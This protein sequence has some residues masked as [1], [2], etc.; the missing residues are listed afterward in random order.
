MEGV[1]LTIER[2]R[3]V[4]RYD[5]ETGICTWTKK[6]GRKV[7]V[8]SRAGHADPRTGYR[9]IRIDGHQILEHRIVWA[10]IHGE[11][12]SYY[13]DHWRGAEVG[14]KLENLRPASCSQNNANRRMSTTNTSGV[15][16]V[17]FH[18]KVGRWRASIKKN[19]QQK[20]LGYFD[21]LEDAAVAYRTAAVEL[22]GEFANF[23]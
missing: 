23:G 21:T 3:E 11:W 1:I 6:T 9:Y 20:H 15:K 8:G 10:Y 19:G 12:P 16:G 4:L 14:N 17:S 7:V 22:F 13:I 2:I 5:P 18:K